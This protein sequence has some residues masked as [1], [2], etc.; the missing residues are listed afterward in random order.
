MSDEETKID[1]VA[2][3]KIM[4]DEYKK[5]DGCATDLSKGAQKTADIN[6]PTQK[7]GPHYHDHDGQENEKMS[8]EETEINQVAKAKIMSREYKENDGCATDLSRGAQKTADIKYPTQKGGPHYHDHDGQENEKMSDEE[9]EIDQVAK[10]KIMSR[11][12]K[13]ND[14][15]ATD[16]SRGAQK[17][18]DIK[19]PT[20]KGGPHYH[21]HDGQ[22][23]EKMSDE[24]TEIDQVA[25][26]KIMSREYKENDGC[27]TDLSRG[28]QKTA[29]IN[30]PTQKGGPH[31]HESPHCQGS[32]DYH[33]HDEQ[34]NSGGWGCVLL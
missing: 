16:L 28:A 26:A 14:G 25:K 30:Y 23:N 18:A 34:E 31:Y 13:E 4:S 8:D 27:A 6:Y 19:Y 17:T 12:Y 21:D 15:C 2:K 33:D 29:D 20:Q 11:E 32:C 24:E 3:A 1:Q 9:T 5:N 22:E 10:A 7:G